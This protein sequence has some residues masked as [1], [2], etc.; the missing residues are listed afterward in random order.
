MKKI[1]LNNL[2]TLCV[3]IE[4]KNTTCKIKPWNF[5]SSLSNCT[6]VGIWLFTRRL[7]IVLS[8]ITMF[9]FFFFFASSDF[10]TWER[11][12]AL[13]LLMLKMCLNILDQLL[14]INKHKFN[15]NIYVRSSLL[16]PPLNCAKL[17][18]DLVNS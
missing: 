14:T 2:E 6:S 4:K 9:L 13:M 5:S 1:M 18:Y 3:F 8:K 15:E 11:W 12:R 16:R 17:F 10:G 7:T